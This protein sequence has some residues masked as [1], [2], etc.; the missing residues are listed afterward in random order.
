V[1]A[2]D[3]DLAVQQAKVED[4]RDEAVRKALEDVNL[5]SRVGLDGDD[6]LVLVGLLEA[7]ADTI[8]VPPVPRP[9]RKTST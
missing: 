5:V 3:E 6:L 7:A 1:S 8:R 2:A 9:A 4:R